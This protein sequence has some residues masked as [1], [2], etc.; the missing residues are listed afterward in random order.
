M[1]QAS[2]KE[3]LGPLGFAASAALSLIGV[4]LLAMLASRLF[5]AHPVLGAWGDPHPCALVPQVGLEM[6]GDARGVVNTRPGV[7][8]GVPQEFRLCQD[9][10]SASTR[11]LFSV[12]ALVD[13]VWLVGFLLIALHLTRVA[14]Q[15]GLFT[16]AVARVTSGLGRYLLVGSFIVALVRAICFS[17]G[18]SHLVTGYGAMSGV[19]GNFHWSWAAILGGV[20][21][22]CV[23]RVM[24]QTIPMREE[25]EAT[26]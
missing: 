6:T 12:P 7:S 3:P 11:A 18:T 15:Q 25:I 21:A 26:V 8:V 14:R 23:A 16:K 24:H 2:S 13:F 10:M 19:V 5:G 20:A 4:G 22:I 9:G 17:V 1:R